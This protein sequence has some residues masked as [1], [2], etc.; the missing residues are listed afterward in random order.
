MQ[1]FDFPRSRLAFCEGQSD[2]RPFEWGKYLFRKRGRNKFSYTLV[3]FHIDDII[4]YPSCFAHDKMEV[5]KDQGYKVN[6]VNFTEGITG[7]ESWVKKGPVE[8]YVNQVPD[9]SHHSK[10]TQARIRN[11]MNREIIIR[12]PSQ[13]EAMK[14]FQEWVEWADTRHFMVFK[15]HYRRWLEMYFDYQGPC[16][17][18]GYYQGG[19]LVG[20]MGWEVCGKEAQITIAKHNRDLRPEVLWL[21]GLQEIFH[22]N[23]GLKKVHCG[24]TADQLKRKLG[25]KESPSWVIMA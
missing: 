9:L 3:S 19:M 18:I 25:M 22:H 20:I 6:S 11:Y 2:A 17:L 4:G 15:G 12:D 23:P 7:T 13:P 1:Y 5:L 24:S 21:R 14:I 16:T 10:K 8:F